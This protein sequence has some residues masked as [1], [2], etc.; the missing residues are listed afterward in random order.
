[1]GRVLINAGE[2]LTEQLL[3][4]LRKRGYAEV[5]IRPVEVASDVLGPGARAKGRGTA[6]TDEDILLL[7]KAIAER[8][9]SVGP[10][11]VAMT[12]LKFAVERV[13]VE[14]LAARKGYKS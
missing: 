9:S 1:M 10:S 13:L 12:N 14:R 3:V 6:S 8:F 2:P 7:K 5:D 11:D 4:V